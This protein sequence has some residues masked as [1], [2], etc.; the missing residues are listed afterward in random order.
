MSLIVK[1]GGKVVFGVGSWVSFNRKFSEAD[2]RHFAE[3]LQDEDPVHFKLDQLKAM[4]FEKT[5]VYGAMLNSLFTKA[6]LSTF[7]SPVYL[8][9]SVNFLSPVYVDEEI[10]VRISVASVERTKS[11]KLKCSL[12][13]TIRKI[14]KN[15]FAVTGT[16][17]LLLKPETVVFESRDS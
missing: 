10:E 2:I 8:S 16:G 12:E 6:Y 3:F 1:N 9:Q 15:V 11:Q 14:E 17:L 4:G 13:S 7:I 5:F